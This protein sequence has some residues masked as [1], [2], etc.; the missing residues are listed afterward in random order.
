[1]LALLA[2]CGAVGTASA[3]IQWRI[4]VKFILGPSGQMS[5]NAGA[6]TTNGVDLASHQAV[7]TNINYANQ[8][9][10]RTGRGFR[11]NLIGIQDEGGAS[12]FFNLSAWSETNTVSLEAAAT[13]SAAASAQFLWRDDAINVYIN[14]T[15]SGVC[16][17]VGSG[18]IV[19]TGSA[20]GAV[21]DSV[22]SARSGHIDLIRAASSNEPMTITR[23]LTLR[24]TCGSVS[25]GIP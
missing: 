13:T 5:T 23:P 7:T 16:S 12:S 6:F 11:F 2:I 8:L 20:F 17:F 9:L 21:R 24:A 4:S 19:F 18:T 25:T 3:Q 1:M 14:N 15:S 10:D 22:N